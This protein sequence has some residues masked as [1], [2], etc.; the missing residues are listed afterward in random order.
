MQLQLTGDNLNKTLWV[1]PDHIQKTRTWWHIDATGLTLGKLATI[2]SNRLLGKH[3]AY[4]CDMWDCGD[5]VVVS[6]ASKIVVTGNKLTDKVYYTHS[7]H[8]GHL[9]ETTLTNLLNK[10]PDRVI[11]LAVKGMLPKNKLRKPRLK[12]LKLFGASHTYANQPLVAL[13]K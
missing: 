1:H 10:H 9:K 6:N 5:F 8:K 13:E 2:I 7:G 12:R 3:K 11:M 4:Y